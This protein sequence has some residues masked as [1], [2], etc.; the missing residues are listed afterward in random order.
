MQALKICL[1]GFAEEEQDGLRALLEQACPMPVVHFTSPIT[2]TH[3]SLV[4]DCD[5]ILARHQAGADW[6]PQ[7]LTARKLHHVYEPVVVLT[8]VFSAEL[9]LRLSN[10][11]ADRVIPLTEVWA[12][13][14]EC[15]EAF[16][17]EICVD[18]PKRLGDSR[19]GYV[20]DGLS[21]LPR[22]LRT[23][24]NS[25]A[26]TERLLDTLDAMVLVLTPEGEI[27]FMNRKTEEASGYSL[28]EVA[29]RTVAEIFLVPEEVD[30]VMQVLG[31]LR[32]KNFPNRHQ[33][34]WLTRE[35][36]L[37]RIE[38]SNPALTD[39]SGEVGY[40][41]AM[42][43]DITDA[44][45][46][47]QE[48]GALERRFSRV[49]NTTMIGIAILACPEGKII[50]AND[51]LARI[52]G[53]D[54]LDMTGKN[55]V[56][57]ALFASEEAVKDAFGRLTQQSGPFFLETPI[58]T[59]DHRVRHVKF[60]L[61]FFDLAGQSGYLL[62][63]QDITEQAQ[64][65]ERY[66]QL[67][68]ELEARVLGAVAEQDAINRELRNEISFREAIQSSSQRLTEIIW[69]TPDI[70]AMADVGGKMRYLNKAGRRIVGLDDAESVAHLSVY[71]FYPSDHQQ[72][73]RSEVMPYV[74]Q[75]DVWQGEAALVFEDGRSI[76]IS[77]VILCHRDE[78]GQVQFF[79]SI[80]RDISKQ[81]E[82][83]ERLQASY[84]R[85]KRLG[86]MRNNLFSM[87]SHQ[88]RTPLSTILSSA[89]L[90][91]HYGQN[92]EPQK[93]VTHLKRIQ[94][95]VRRMEV[96]LGGILQLSQMESQ[97]ET[98]HAEIELVSFCKRALDDFNLNIK[99]SHPIHFVSARREMII[100]TDEELLRRVLDNLLSNAIKYSAPGKRVD[101]TVE[102]E[103]AWVKLRVS[104]QGIGI[105]P[106][107]L[108]KLF[109]P[110]FR[111]KN[112]A[113]IPG[114][115][116]GLMIVK[117]SLELM[118]GTIEVSSHVG[119][120]TS[121]LVRFPVQEGHLGG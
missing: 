28:A 30:E 25:L 109:D 11:G 18:A 66:A 35:G 91:E 54:P 67:N 56:E 64:A 20:L 33:N 32:N 114:N 108:T 89:E 14:P 93:R 71:Q 17:P 63:V 22:F 65:E 53:M 52:V 78:R 75:H 61:D 92:W 12:L 82:Y 34:S 76:P 86:E 106:E 95:A 115:G 50:Q 16:F 13:L 69:E 57:S 31:A 24:K 7:F 48:L 112:V 121:V 120:G 36:K 19:A 38:W 119:A 5:L 97:H 51:G 46:Q 21:G 47:A 73:I 43:L 100:R 39:D 113:D 68:A 26:F 3:W 40:I 80:A 44:H 85:E 103:G 98:Q 10:L 55:L 87:T 9:V 1:M 45:Q 83:E 96:L 111:G 116:L 58:L 60:S 70:V 110:F 102:V 59:Q 79:S 49:F 99:G 107:D 88:F 84:N 101:L 94:E 104:D 77:Q 81:K 74:L 117:K 37:L 8:E 27:V 2:A 118:Q 90:L 62:L 23:E 15:L 42:G 6:V 29:G 72:H 41:I 105:P 4:T